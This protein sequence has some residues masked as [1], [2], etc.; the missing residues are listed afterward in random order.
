MAADADLEGYRPD[1]YFSRAWA[2]LTR[3][4][5]WIKPVLVMSAALL[6]PVGGLFGVLGYALEW[7]R[8]T[9]WGVTSAPKQRGVRVGDCIASGARAFVVM[10]VWG[11]CWG[12]V[13]GLL[14][15]VPLLGS[16][17]SFAWTILNLFAILVIMVAVLRAT[18]YQRIR[19]GLRASTVWRM[20]SHDPGGLMRVFGLQLAGDAIIAAVGSIVTFVALMSALPQ[21]FY[22]AGY[23][24]EFSGLMSD[25]MRAMVVLQFVGAL[26][27]S[28]LPALVVTYVLVV[29][30]TVVLTLLVY[31][32]LALWVRQFD[33]PAWGREEDPM[34]FESQDKAAP[35]AQ[36]LPPVGATSP[37]PA[38][39]HAEKDSAPAAPVAEKDVEPAPPAPAA[40]SPEPSVPADPAPAEPAPADESPVAP[41]D[42]PGAEDPSGPIDAP[43][44]PAE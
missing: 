41:G 43:E 26:L 34:P 37:E 40:Q 16:L 24:S 8:L 39:P 7:A 6:V 44:R 29:P 25:S 5:G 22:L 42:A 21:L 13:G 11:L 4:R 38:A 17:F 14:S 10:L 12:F 18:I 33:V 27:S 19:A 20:V 9:A 2:L 28:A 35:A 32:A 1:H 15:A 23:L 30:A 3:D 36:P 31:T